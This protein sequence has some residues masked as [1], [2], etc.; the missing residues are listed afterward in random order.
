MKKIDIFGENCFETYTKVREASRGI[1]VKDGRILLSHETV[2]GCWMIPGGGREEG[3]TPEGCCMREIE[4]ETGLIVRTLQQFLE[5]NEYYE[6]Y[7]YLSR[8][9]VC[10]VAGKGRLQLTEAES[11][12]GVRPEWIPLE[13][14][15]GIFSK[16]A[17]Y[18]A[19]SEEKR[20]IYQREDAALRAYLEGK[21]PAE[22]RHGTI[23]V[24]ETTK[25]DLDDVRRLWA[26]G[27]VMRYVGFPDGLI[28]T[29]EQMIDWFEWI[30]TGRPVLNHYS[31]FED[32]RYCGESYYEID[33]EHESAA[34]DIKLF[35][36]ARG[37][38]IAAAGL[39]H[40]I[41]EAFKNGAK[42]L[43]VDPLPENVKA[44][45]LYERLGFQRK[46]FPEHLR[47]KGEEW[48]SVYMELHKD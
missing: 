48:K 46:D 12:R 13:E 31:V 15:V 6:E 20:G 28:K 2:S 3:E 9:Y 30:E 17:S 16:H 11:D 29:D 33:A 38:G 32:G 5:L 40:A 44:I 41:A 18:A 10:E 8:Y 34:L 35:G 45:A 43:W 24:K 47:S 22:K 36:F 42:T 19:E 26:D 7:R 21:S 39:S 23:E 14:A 27:D 1:V 4:E 25:D 37:R